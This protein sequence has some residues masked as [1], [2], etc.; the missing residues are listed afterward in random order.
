MK[1]KLGWYLQG[2][3]TRNW[4]TFEKQLDRRRGWRFRTHRAGVALCTTKR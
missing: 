4:D 1:F 3:A 2:L